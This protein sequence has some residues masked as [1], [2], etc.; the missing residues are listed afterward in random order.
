[1][2]SLAANKPTVR[3]ENWSVVNDVISPAYRDLVPGYRLTGYT[4]QYQDR[5][6]GLIY[7]SAILAV[8]PDASRVETAEAIY[9]LGRA[10]RRYERW[11][12][13]SSIEDAA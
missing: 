5:P 6:C 13:G 12:Q 9:L 1:M 7:S 11:Y 8:N 4:L 2:D 3:I 10:D